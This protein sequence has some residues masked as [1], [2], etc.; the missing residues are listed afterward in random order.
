MYHSYSNQSIDL[1]P[2]SVDWFLYGKEIGRSIIQLTGFYMRGTL[3]AK[4]LTELI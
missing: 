1:P 3:I 4:G 2:K